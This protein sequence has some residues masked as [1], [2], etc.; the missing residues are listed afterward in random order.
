MPDSCLMVYLM[1]CLLRI[2]E[3]ER[4]MT[5]PFTTYIFTIIKARLAAPN[6]PLSNI[7]V[8]AVVVKKIM[9]VNSK[10]KKPATILLLKLFWDREM[11]K[12]LRAPNIMN[13][14]RRVINNWMPSDI[15]TA[16]F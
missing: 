11:A 9:G 6:P 16:P 15:S 1:L 8:N 4:R 2:N 12:K 14:N 10:N 3:A 13:E 7:E 5:I